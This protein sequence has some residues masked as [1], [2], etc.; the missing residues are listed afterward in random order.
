MVK[1]KIM[2]SRIA[3]PV[4]SETISKT[5]A[6][7]YISNAK[8][9]EWGKELHVEIIGTDEQVEEALNNLERRGARVSRFE[10]RVTKDRDICVDC[11]AC[12]TICPWKV[13]RIEGDWTINLESDKCP[14][15]C[16]L[17]VKCCPVRALVAEEQEV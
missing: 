1:Y 4:I 6:Q 2:A 15:G 13:I 8:V 5:G 3:E 7:F 9:G 11:G 14:P 10:E 17:C 12:V 16:S